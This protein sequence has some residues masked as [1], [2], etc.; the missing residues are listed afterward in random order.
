MLFIVGGL[1]DILLHRMSLQQRLLIHF[2]KIEQKLRYR[3]FKLNFLAWWT[4][5]HFAV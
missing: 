3:M 1:D 5:V 2:N 4:F